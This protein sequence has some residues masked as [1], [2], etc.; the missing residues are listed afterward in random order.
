MKRKIG[1]ILDENLVFKA[2]GVAIYKRQS[3]SHLLEDALR[4]YLETIEKKEKKRGISKNTQGAMKLP[5]NLLK[6]VMEEEDFYETG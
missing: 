5:K 1:T 3:L 4:M 2:K 6:S